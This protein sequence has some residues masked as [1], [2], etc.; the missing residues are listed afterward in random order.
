MPE[1]WAFISSTIAVRMPW[2]RRGIWFCGFGSTER[3]SGVK[4]PISLIR[5]SRGASS[6]ATLVRVG[7][8]DAYLHPD[9]HETDTVDY[10]IVMA[11][12][13]WA[14]LEDKETLL[15]A[16][17]VLIQRGTNHAW[18]NRSDEC[19]RIAF[20]LIDGGR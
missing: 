11:G 17:N 9:M 14:I 1:C 16:G 13:I 10:A 18:A 7:L 12:E 4:G 20:V 2:K 19:A 6:I 8:Q 3:N 15:R 5:C